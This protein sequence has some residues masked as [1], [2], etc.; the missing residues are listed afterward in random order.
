MSIGG[1]S[2]KKGAD[3]TNGKAVVLQLE[4]ERK[5]R[6]TYTDNQVSKKAGIGTGTVARY[7]KIM[8]AYKCFIKFGK[9]K[10]II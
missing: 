6:E 2:D 7:N 1:S 10:G 4:G 5:N 8:E 3:I 9:I